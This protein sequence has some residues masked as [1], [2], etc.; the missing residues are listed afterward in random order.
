MKEEE[1]I[2][3]ILNEAFYIHK[4][5][6]PGM[7]EKYIKPVLLTG[8]VSE[9]YLLKQKKRFRFFLKKLKWIAVI[10]QTWL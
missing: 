9:A 3:I 6:G 1:I 8:F 4:T 5:I 7:L 2:T 10:E